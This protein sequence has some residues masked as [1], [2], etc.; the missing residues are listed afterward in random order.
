MRI[1][2]QYTTQLK[3]S[4]GVPEEEIELP[5]SSSVNDLVERLKVQH[6]E[7]FTKFALDA[8]GTLLPN[9]VVCVDD[10]QVTLPDQVDLTEGSTVMFLSAI[11]GG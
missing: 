3:A 10:Q 9:L 4:L 11:S 2:V 7:A 5:P 1:S 6:G 8:S